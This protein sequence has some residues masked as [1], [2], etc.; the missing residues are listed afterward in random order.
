[1]RRRRLDV[2]G[3]SARRLGKNPAWRFELVRY[4]R[5]LVPAAQMLEVPAPEPPSRWPLGAE[6]RAVLEDRLAVAGL[7]GM[8]GASQRGSRQHPGGGH[9]KPAPPPGRQ[10]E[11][12]NPCRTI[13]WQGG[14]WGG[15]MEVL[16][17]SSKSSPNSCA[18][19]M[20]GVVRSSG[21]VEVQ[22]VGAGALNQAVKAI[23]IA[24]GYLA[25]SGVDLVCVPSFAD[26]E[27][28]GERRTAMRLLVEDRER[29]LPMAGEAQ[30]RPI[31]RPVPALAEEV[32]LSRLERPQPVAQVAEPVNSAH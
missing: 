17:V 28:D 10:Q 14:P 6:V 30:E 13:G 27:I 15:R 26:I 22:V 25:A 4:D 18:G 16:K 32:A 23:A 7:D 3:H 21:A 19:A 11:I 31:L 1:M 2:Y 9:L 12:A 24:R 29:R 20:A 8:S 5:L